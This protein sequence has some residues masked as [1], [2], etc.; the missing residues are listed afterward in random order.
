M[1]R[2]KGKISNRIML[3]VVSVMILMYA[4]SLLI[5]YQGLGTS[6]ETTVAEYGTGMAKNIAEKFNGEKYAEFLKD[7]KETRT[8]WELRES[9]NEFREK[10]GAL[11]VYTITSKGDKEYI[12]IDG[13][14][15]GSKSASGIMEETTGDPKE[16]VP[17]LEGKTSTSQ[18][19]DDGQYGYYL[20]SF[21]PIKN[22]KEEVIGVLGV[23]IDASSVNEIKESVMKKIVV[24]ASIVNTIVVL[25]SI[26]I[27]TISIRRKLKPLGKLEEIA[28]QMAEGQFKKAEKDVK[29]IK[30]KSDNE[31]TTL[32]KAFE[33][34]VEK[35][36]EMIDNIEQ[37]ANVLGDMS[38][39]M[40]QE[41]QIMNNANEEITNAVSDIE[42]AT[43]TQ[44]TLSKE[45]LKA[46]D[47][48]SNGM[49]G[50]AER[51]ASATNQT[52]NIKEN[53]DKGTEQLSNLVVKIDRLDKTVEK[54]NEKMSELNQQIEEIN[55]MAN[56]IEE[57]SNQTNLLALNASIEAARAGGYGKGFIVV[58]EEVKKLAERSREV[59]KLIREKLKVFEETIQNSTE[60]MKR[61]S[62]QTKEGK[63]SAGKV[64]E[65]FEQIVKS[66]EVITENMKDISLTTHNQSAYSEEVSVSFADFINLTQHTASLTEE[67]KEQSEV[68][69]GIMENVVNMAK[70]MKE[71]SEKIQNYLKKINK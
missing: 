27:I 67:T 53:I 71:T 64:E 59:T 57:V 12:L 49:M 52:I 9:L 33:N 50:I 55:E 32:V 6:V 70:E 36:K 60:R 20:S 21:A 35:N 54:S 38:K 5:L 24:I 16:L 43:S 46:I 69:K 30:T 39:N 44:I 22:K 18:I 63:E 31:I 34:M 2:K 47:N 14:Y 42:G 17:V 7:K 28:Q 8:Y 56:I 26:F 1:K 4:C 29:K 19:I 25:I 23:D 13:Q 11:Y 51:T 15:R 10:T 61:S 37:T 48:S 68:Q 45:T 3:Y 62:E 40:H 41:M 58:S 65:N 66:M